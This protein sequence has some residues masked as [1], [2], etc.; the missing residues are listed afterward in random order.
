MGASR[1]T[2]TTRIGAHA[3][4]TSRMVQSFFVGVREQRS[5]ACQRLNGDASL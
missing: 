4:A 1:P 3:A 2:A 5:R